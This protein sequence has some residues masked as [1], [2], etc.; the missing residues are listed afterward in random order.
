M[1]TNNKVFFQTGFRN[2]NWISLSYISPH[3]ELPLHWA[4]G[5]VDK[6]EQAVKMLNMCAPLL[7]LWALVAECHQ[8]KTLTPKLSG[9]LLRACCATGECHVRPVCLYSV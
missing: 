4:I 7:E 3:V 9:H 8:V 2:P 6:P 1:M 5:W